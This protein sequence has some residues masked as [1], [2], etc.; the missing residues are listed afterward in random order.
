M[1]WRSAVPQTAIVPLPVPDDVQG[2]IPV[3]AP[4]QL[5][6]A[7]FAAVFVL[8]FGA[9]GCYAFYT[10]ASAL[11]RG[12]VLWWS[13]PV[14]VLEAANEEA[15][16]EDADVE[17]IGTARPAE[18]TVAAPFTHA[19]SLVAEWEV[20]EFDT[21]GDDREWDTIA[22]G[23]EQVPF[24]LEDDTGSI[25]IEPAESDLTL[26][27]GAEVEVGRGSTA[28][29]PIATFLQ[30]ADV[31]PGAG[32]ESSVGPLTVATG[33]RRRYTEHRIDPGDDV[34]VYG[35]VERDLGAATATGDVNAA[36]R[37]TA[38]DGLFLLSDTGERSTIVR[39][40]LAGAG[41]TLFSLPFLAGSAFSA[42]VAIDLL[43]LV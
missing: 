4:A 41:M 31:D 21:S 22:S 16:D 7:G 28:D 3:I 14:S 34:H 35:P 30:E 17:L 1:R 9:A 42:W 39:S 37:S 15:G 43:G 25:L 36:V 13:D 29:E 33:D 26:T 32:N 19:T 11:Y 10:G 18:E 2:V 27:T 12:V 38:G 23:R 40:L 24:R 8:A 5:G 20:E 6:I